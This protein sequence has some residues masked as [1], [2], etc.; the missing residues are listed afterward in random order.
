[1][2]MN[3]YEEHPSSG[4]ASAPEGSI[5]QRNGVPEV[6]PRMCLQGTRGQTRRP[7]HRITLFPSIHVQA[8]IDQLN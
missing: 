4:S 6:Q 3:Y 7:M 5:L 2:S 1:M 8:R